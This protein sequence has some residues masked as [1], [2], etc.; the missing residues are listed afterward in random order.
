MR[1]FKVFTPLAAVALL[2]SPPVVH[3]HGDEDHG[4][5]GVTISSTTNSKNALSVVP[6][7]LDS[8][9][10]PFSLVD[11]NGRNVTQDSFNGKHTLV[12]FGYV[13]CQ[14][15]CSI[16][17]NRIGTALELLQQ[18]DKNLEDRLV[19]LVVT[20]DPESDTP[21]KMRSALEKYHPLLLGLT[22]DDSE[23]QQIYTAYNQNP[24]PLDQ[25]INGENVISHQSYF[26][27]MGPDGS[28]R[29]LFPP[30]LSAESMAAVLRKYISES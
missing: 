12:F 5:D 7:A 9:G 15:M 29:T 13:D 3:A 20:V 30:I 17:L 21:E 18:E 22:G 19:P 25:T 10:G 26:Y 1:L 28:F 27:L 24:A 4:S 16:S 14:I 23:L 8:V 6:S 2:C 11:H